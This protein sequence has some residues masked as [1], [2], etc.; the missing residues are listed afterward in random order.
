[1]KIVFRK[2]FQKR[3]I[4]KKNTVTLWKTVEEE[5]KQKKVCTAIPGR[6]KPDH[7]CS[8][9]GLRRAR[10]KATSIRDVIMR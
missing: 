8:A 6:C 7:N 10:G 3:L 9:N 2:T 5:I 4:I 1:M